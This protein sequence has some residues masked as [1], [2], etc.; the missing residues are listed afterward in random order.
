MQQLIYMATISPQPNNNLSDSDIELLSAYL[1][2]QLAPAERR[3]LEQRMQ[4]EPLLQAELEE[5]RFT[6]ALL[7]NLPALTPP[8]SFTLDATI[9][10]PPRWSFARLL[11]VGIG[12][13]LAL[14]P[15]GALATVLLLVVA[16]GT[17]MYTLQLSAPQM[18]MAPMLPATSSAGGA[19]SAYSTA[20]VQPTQLPTAAAQ[21]DEGQ[22]AP[23]SEA[24]PTE[25]DEAAAAEM[26]EPVE[27]AAPAM[28][29]AIRPPAAAQ[30]ADEPEQAGEQDNPAD[31]SAAVVLPPPT[32]RSPDMGVLTIQPEGTR[33]PG[34]GSTDNSSPDTREVQPEVVAPPI[35][36]RS[37]GVA[38][39]YMLPLLVALAAFALALAGWFI[40][41][42]RSRRT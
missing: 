11:S 29:E 21:A 12:G 5:L 41:R 39:P 40:W 24:A 37:R 13:S 30:P 6:I 27:E 34:I 32:P 2:D 35:Q 22:P 8:R 17:L 42:R 23:L 14:R 25:A 3:H 10:Q 33:P 18:A 9:V 26:A 4:V 16:V 36:E 28:G 15:A 7:D 19:E 31:S 20:R 1:D 38:P